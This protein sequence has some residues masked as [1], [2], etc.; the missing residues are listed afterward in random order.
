MPFLVVKVTFSQSQAQAIAKAQALLQHPDNVGV[1]VIDISE[2]PPF[3]NPE[4][5]CSNS[6]RV[7]QP[8][9]RMRYNEAKARHQWGPI[10]VNGCTWLG[11]SHAQFRLSNESKECGPTIWKLI[12]WGSC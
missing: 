3:A 10:V 6:N 7:T 2:D 12:Q 8:Q 5:D 9:W 11:S 1:I 4:E